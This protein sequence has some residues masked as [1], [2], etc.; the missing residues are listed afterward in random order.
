MLTKTIIFHG[1]IIIDRAK[2]KK[3]EDEEDRGLSDND[4]WVSG[5]QTGDCVAMCTV[6]IQEQTKN[7]SCPWT[8]FNKCFYYLFPTVQYISTAPQGISDKILNRM[9]NEKFFTGHN[10]LS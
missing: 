2:G 6:H 5:D 10:L 3:E 7:R 4:H 8:R 9:K 1:G